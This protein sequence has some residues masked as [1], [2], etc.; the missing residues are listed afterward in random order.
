MNAFNRLLTL[1]DAEKHRRGIEYTPGE[2]AQQPQAWKKTVETLKDR[3]REVS[4]FL[5]GSGLTGTTENTVIL[6]GA[7]TSEFIGNSI[8]NAL[9]MKL[10]REV[11]SIPTTHLV[12][13]ANEILVPGHAYTVV[14]FARSGNSPESVAT[15]DFVRRLFPRVRQIAITCNPDGALAGRTQG[16]P[17]ALCILLPGETNDRSLAMTSSF[18]SMALAGIALCY[19]D[20]LEDLASIVESAAEAGR[21]LIDRYAD[22]V[23]DYASREFRRA[24]YLG[25]SAL[26]G[27]MQEC[28]LKM[29]EMTNGEV[30]TIFNSY[31]GIRHGPQAFI[32]DDCIVL[33]SLSSNASVRRYETDFLRELKEK[34]QGC[35]TL[36]VCNRDAGDLR[37]WGSDVIELFPEADGLED[38]FRIMTDVVAG[39]MLATFKSLALGYKPDSPSPTGAIHRVVEGVTIYDGKSIRR[40]DRATI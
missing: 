23:A 18:S 16:D 20:D 4:D 13:H 14:S 28:A 6:T 36:L 12:T 1:S 30:A 3:Q 17:D 34:A 5:L 38:C 32:R 7:G 31:L 35:G 9:R 22:L 39:Q 40:G 21:S 27:T 19:A 25:S 11:L 24:C 10:R 29:Q 2:I 37:Q 33:A 26:Y 15:Y 8:V